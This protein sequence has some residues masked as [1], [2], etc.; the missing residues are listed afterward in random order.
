MI[1]TDTWAVRNFILRVLASTNAIGAGIINSRKKIGKMKARVS[2]LPN[3]YK[4]KPN[5]TM[6]NEYAEVK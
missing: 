2:F 1:N 5:R 4:V 3:K 6:K